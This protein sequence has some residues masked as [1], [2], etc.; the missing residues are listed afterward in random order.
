VFQRR[1]KRNW[2]QNAKE[3]L[4]PTAGW[5]R[6]LTYWG[7]RIIRME[8]TP[9]S[10]AAGLA[11][12]AAVSMTPFLGLHF[13]LAALIAWA[14]GANALA[15]LIGTF[16]GNPWT[17]P[18]IWLMIYRIGCLILGI[19]PGAHPNFADTADGFFSNPFDAVMPTLG[20]MMV[21]AVPVALATWWIVY[22]PVRRIVEIRQQHRR[23]R[24]AT[25]R[26][27]GKRT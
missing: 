25:A 22:I 20:P 18:F 26:L 6:A 3:A 27:R 17:F 2:L 15:G 21:G 16:I 14:I 7:H 19:E 11:C 24:L 12:G 13:V 10:I 9:Y 23:E 5:L 8:G 1:N 4:W